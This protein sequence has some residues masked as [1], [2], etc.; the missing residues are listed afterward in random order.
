MPFSVQGSNCRAENTEGK[1]VTTETERERE[2][3]VRYKCDDL[4]Y[5]KEGR[6]G[7]G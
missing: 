5:W 4:R 3:L 1:E 7:R 6:K 2:N